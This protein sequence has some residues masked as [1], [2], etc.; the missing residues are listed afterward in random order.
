MADL[1]ITADTITKRLFGNNPMKYARALAKK[2]KSRIT[3]VGAIL[4]AEDGGY[5]S[6][7]VNGW[8]VKGEL[9]TVQE[10]GVLVSN[11][12]V[13]HAEEVC[14]ARSARAGFCTKNATM[15]VS[16]S[17][18]FVCGRLILAAGIKKVI[19]GDPWWD[20]AVLKYLEDNGVVVERVK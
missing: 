19:Y 1:G 3:G 16:T 15:Y 18:C 10:D 12:W 20:K 13:I 4:F 14:I 9:E 8:G 5:M 6:A 2:S 17:P 7:G 11:P